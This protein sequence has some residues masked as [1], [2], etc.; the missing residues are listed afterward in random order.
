M[1]VKK[2]GEVKLVIRDLMD[3]GLE[4]GSKTEQYAPLKMDSD[5]MT[6]A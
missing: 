1:G 5:I 3:C 6:V 4:G 2:G